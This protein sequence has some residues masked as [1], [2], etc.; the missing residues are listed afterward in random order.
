MNNRYLNGNQINR[1]QPKKITLSFDDM[2][3]LLRGKSENA[4]ITFWHKFIYQ[5]ENMRVLINIH[6]KLT[7]KLSYLGLININPDQVKY[8]DGSVEI[9]EET[10]KN[11]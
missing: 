1:K 6:R 5:H 2:L 4:Q 8:D 3:A 7:Q 10:I 11:R 9:I